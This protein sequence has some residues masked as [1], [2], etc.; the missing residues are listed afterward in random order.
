MSNH[1][2]ETLA[3]EYPTQPF[4]R[5]PIRSHP[6]GRPATVLEVD[7]HAGPETL[8]MGYAQAAGTFMLDGSL[9]NQ[10]PFEEIKRK[11]LVSGQGG[12]GVVGIERKKRESG[13]L[14]AFGFSNIGESLGG[15][16][17]GRELSSMKEMRSVANPR[18]MP[19]L[20]MPPSILFVDLQLAP[21]ESK[22]F[23]Y[24][25]TLPKGLPPSH[26]GRA[27]KFS[28]QITIGI[29]RSASSSGQKICSVD[30]PF[31]VF[32]T[33]TPQGQVL[34]YDLLSPFVYL[35]DQAHTKELKR[36]QQDNPASESDLTSFLTYANVLL[37]QMSST[38]SGL[39]SPTGPL[40]PHVRRASSI[41]EPANSKEAIDLAILRST[42][43]SPAPGPN[44]LSLSSRFSISRSSRPVAT[45]FFPRTS[46]R[47]GETIHL[48]I[49]VQPDPI[50]TPVEPARV[51]EANPDAMQTQG[52]PVPSVPVYFVLVTLETSETVEPAIALRSAQSILRQTRKVHASSAESALYARRLAF[53]LAIPASGT[54][55]FHTSG[56]TLDWRARI[57]FITP[58]LR[59]Q[60]NSTRRSS[61]PE[62]EEL[63]AEPE[64]ASRPLQEQKEW[65][66]LLAKVAA[67]ERG[68]LLQGVDRLA[69]ESFE[70]AIPLRVFGAVVGGRAESDVDDLAI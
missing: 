22:S 59:A 15:L 56:V 52:S 32:G 61:D 25:F 27:V 16:L 26:K 24:S 58:R 62:K 67:D 42:Q 34:A 31:R 40:P 8:M 14:G 57:E 20:G 43:K 1:S 65:E 13:L 51:G 38:S 45:L 29:Q 33:V 3:S 54:P 37:E 28:Y 70:V 39:L 50:K 12:G 68:D 60:S 4:V 49:D 66:D 7:E 36:E 53:S 5:Q 11:A 2:D 17:G 30:V 6:F 63:T 48:V 19:L 23:S 55:G 21:G 9:V 41:S 18:S 44:S 46:Y 64:D 10:A 35:R 69:V 47:L